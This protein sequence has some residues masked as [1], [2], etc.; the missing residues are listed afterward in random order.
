MPLPRLELE[1][2]HDVFMMAASEGRGMVIHLSPSRR[3]LSAPA[4]ASSL[5]CLQEIARLRFVIDWRRF[6]WLAASADRQ[7][8]RLRAPRRH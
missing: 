3:C 6:R 7:I 4:L 1:R 8:R 2:A 5:P